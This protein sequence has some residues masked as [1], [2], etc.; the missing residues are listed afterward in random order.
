VLRCCVA[1]RQGFV[2]LT[3]PCLLRMRT[4][5]KASCLLRVCIMDEIAYQSVQLHQNGQPPAAPTCDQVC[6][7]AMRPTGEV[8]NSG[9]VST[10]VNAPH[11]LWGTSIRRHLRRRIN[12][13]GAAAEAPGRRGDAQAR[14]QVGQQEGQGAGG[15]RGRGNKLC[16]PAQHAFVKCRRICPIRQFCSAAHYPPTCAWTA[17]WWDHN[18]QRRTMVH[19][20][21]PMPNST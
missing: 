12:P 7:V 8:N 19:K 9:V 15:G 18:T 5:L 11:V 4:V 10:S 20:E 16:L 3:A 13:Q 17:S 2:L 1:G 14:P 21:Q 6:D